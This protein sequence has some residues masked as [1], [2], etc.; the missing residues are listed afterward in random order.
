MLQNMQRFTQMDLN[1]CSVNKC[2][3]ISG[4]PWWGA[5]ITPDISSLPGATGR[6]T[7]VL[8]WSDGDPVISPWPEEKLSAGCT[9]S[10]SLCWTPAGAEFTFRNIFNVSTR[11]WH[12]VE[13]TP[14][15][16]PAPCSYG[17]KTMQVKSWSGSVD[18]FP[19]RHSLSRCCCAVLFHLTDQWMQLSDLRSRCHCRVPPVVSSSNWFFSAVVRQQTHDLRFSSRLSEQT[20]MWLADGEFMIHISASTG[21]STWLGSLH[22]ALLHLREPKHVLDPKTSRTAAPVIAPAQYRHLGMG[23]EVPS[24]PQCQHWTCSRGYIWVT[25]Q[26]CYSQFVSDYKHRSQYT[27]NTVATSLKYWDAVELTWEGQ[28]NYTFMLRSRFVSGE[29]LQWGRK[30]YRSLMSR[31]TGRCLKSLAV[32]VWTSAAERGCGGA[33]SPTV[34]PVKVHVCLFGWI[35]IC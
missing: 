31:V 28:V 19:C 25:H 18:D 12:S 2:L 34:G 17:N 1:V 20:L 22:F 8:R 23:S 11:T 27:R 14:P 21:Y 29:F 33:S 3:L 32:F 7:Y 13:P 5:V 6:G 30:I 4:S 26:A 24:R 15:D 16:R 35:S 9:W 10:N